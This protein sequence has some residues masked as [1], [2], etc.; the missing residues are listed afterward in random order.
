MIDNQPP[1]QP[2]SAQLKPCRWRRSRRILLALVCS[3]LVSVLLGLGLFYYARS[4]TGGPPGTPRRAPPPCL[5]P[6]C[7]KA[8]ARLS[9]AADPFAQPCDYFLASC[10]AEGPAA[11]TRGRQRGKELAQGKAGLEERAPGN[12]RR[13]GVVNLGKVTDGQPNTDTL[14]DRLADK[15][16]ALLQVL[17][18]ILESPDRPSSA[19]SAEQKV[20][21]FYRSCMDTGTIEKAGPQPALKLIEKLGG[22]AVFGKW[23]RTDFNVIL[24]LLM[25]EYA[26]FPFFS[27]YVGKNPNDSD[28][29]GHRKYIQID[30]PEFHIPVEWDSKKQKSTV[31]VPTLRQLLS[32]HLQLLV[33]LGVPSSSTN[34]HTGMFL[35][36]MSELTL[37]ASPLT[38]R[39]QQQLLYQRM[40]LKELQ[41]AAPAIDWLGC[42]RATFHPIPVNQSDVVLLH[43]LPYII[44]MSKTISKWQRNPEM[45]GSG[46]LHT[47]MILSLLH[48]VIPA[49]NPEFAEI[50]RNLSVGL[51][52]RLDVIPHWKKCILETEKGF[53]TVLTALLKERVGEKEAEE[54][55]ENIYS[56]LKSRL[57]IL[58]WRNEELHSSILNRVGSL[59]LRLSINKEILSQEKIDQQYSEV[60]VS[61]DDYFSNY[62]QTL[63]LQQKRRTKLFSQTTALDIL[64]LTPSFSSEEIN[65]PLGMFVPPAFHPSYPRA[66]NY[67]ILGTLMAKEILYLLLPDIQSQSEAPKKVSDC[68][69]AHYLH[70][71]KS[72]R[73][74]DPPPLTP[75]QQQ[76]IWVQH[77]ALHVA[78]QAYEQ[79]L[80]KY[81]GD[82]SLSSLSYTHLFLASFAQNNCNSDPVK[83]HLPF[84][85]FFLV[86][87]I[88]MN[89]DLCPQPMT[90]SHNSHKGFLQKC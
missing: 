43:N 31:N 21:R 82:T 60:A 76:A 22:W 14:P 39:L 37:A 87:V 72:A 56:S 80:L 84:E 64:S 59:T 81:H 52:D 8:A 55:I 33:L 19:N 47:F 51:G 29:S 62:L 36:L 3:S 9:A 75:A 65:V 28:S 27:V 61:E 30:Q 2:E 63:S 54:F 66:V 24:S 34:L 88:C 32:F 1:S 11:A 85:P 50:Q 18:D 44:H 70:L 49:L 10:R 41:A 25:K 86:T 68:V 12:E 40:T 74:T 79:S 42:L 78:L 58:K 7:L 5:S 67:G 6:D 15:Q 16:T 4:K 69:W 38:H 46:P 77:T 23:N 26:T 45:T 17:R 57:S 73:R 89:S 83:E 48:K 90:C 13:G 35:Q 20:R 53:D 71:T